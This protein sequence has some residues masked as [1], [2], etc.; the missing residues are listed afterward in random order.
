MTME[1][2]VFLGKLRYW[3]GPAEN[4]HDFERAYG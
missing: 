2:H 3:T 4:D 1:D